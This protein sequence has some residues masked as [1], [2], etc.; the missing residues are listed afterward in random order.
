[1][2]EYILDVAVFEETKA[3]ADPIRDIPAGELD[4]EVE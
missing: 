4:L 2:R 3:G 1:M